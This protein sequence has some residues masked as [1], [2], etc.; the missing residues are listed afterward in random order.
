MDTPD[1]PNTPNS[2]D[3][4]DVPAS[5]A[6]RGGRTRPWGRY[7]LIA[8]VSAIALVGASFAGAAIAGGAR[9]VAMASG[10]DHSMLAPRA[11]ADGRG[12]VRP[13]DLAQRGGGMVD[14]AHR[15]R[16]GAADPAQR[17]ERLA[18]L[19][20]ELGIDAD[21]LLA[22]VEDLHAELDVERDALRDELADLEPA[23][24]RA[25]MLEL[26]DAR[27]EALTALLVELGADPV[28]VE[29][30]LDARDAEAH[31]GGRRGQR[32]GLRGGV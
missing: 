10:G 6:T 27:R 4:P 18:A 29:A 3:T 7:A 30:A 21:A 15:E 32:G 9:V 5:G 12:A 17:E 20:E 28:D 8:G 31:D 16:F 23:D 26:A 11:F 24:R 25:R 14:R 1:T 2:Q 22:A 19:A 13:V